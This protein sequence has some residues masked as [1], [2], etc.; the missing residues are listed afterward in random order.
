MIPR[1]IYIIQITFY[2]M[3][4]IK[5]NGTSIFQIKTI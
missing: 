4:M 5:Q 3:K 2:L 1:I